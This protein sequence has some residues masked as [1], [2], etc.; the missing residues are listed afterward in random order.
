MQHKTLKNGR[1]QELSFIEQMANIGGEVE[2]AISWKNK[3][4]ENYS[5]RALER[6]LELLDLTAELTSFCRKKELLRV[7]ETLVDYFYFDNIYR[8]SDDLWRSY[9]NPFGLYARK[10]V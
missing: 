4:N 10:E 6:A 8:S 9:F 1:W 2:R 5:K 3:G 7:R